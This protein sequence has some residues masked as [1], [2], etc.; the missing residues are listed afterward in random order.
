MLFSIFDCGQ[1]ENHYISVEDTT[2]SKRAGF[3]LFLSFTSQE[4]MLGQRRRSSRSGKAKS[5]YSPT[6]SAL[7]R[8][9]KKK[10]K[11]GNGEEDAAAER[12]AR[13]ALEWKAEETKKMTLMQSVLIKVWWSY[14]P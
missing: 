9:A 1:S 5:V 2:S 10:P 3:L 11:V 14:A 6:G 12:I 7:K 4:N 8:G 13:E